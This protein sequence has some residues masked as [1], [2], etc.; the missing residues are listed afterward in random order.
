MRHI[1]RRGLLHRLLNRLST[2]EPRPL[3]LMSDSILKLVVEVLRLLCLFRLVNHRL[4][5]LRM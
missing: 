4:A 1:W 2:A 3:R 5:H